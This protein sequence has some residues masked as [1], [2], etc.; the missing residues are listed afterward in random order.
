[1][2]ATRGLCLHTMKGS[3]IGSLDFTIGMSSQ[4]GHVR[5]LSECIEYNH[6]N[7]IDF[8]PLVVGVIG[9]EAPVLALDR[10]VLRPLASLAAR[11]CREEPSGAGE[12]TCI[13]PFRFSSL[14]TGEESSIDSVG[15]GDKEPELKSSRSR[16]LRFV[17]VVGEVSTTSSWSMASSGCRRS[18]IDSLGVGMDDSPFT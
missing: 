15:G 3:L 1:M 4:F 11:V 16:A 13:S 10:V 12:L 14:T 6:N 7:R 5:L 2:C 17:T 8:R 9:D 18:S